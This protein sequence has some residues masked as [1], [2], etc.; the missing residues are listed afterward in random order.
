MTH[1]TGAQRF[2]RSAARKGVNKGLSILVAVAMRQRSSAAAVGGLAALATPRCLSPRESPRTR[3]GLRFV[4]AK[5]DG[6]LNVA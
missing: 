2:L 4:G 5:L 3:P 6:A 1:V